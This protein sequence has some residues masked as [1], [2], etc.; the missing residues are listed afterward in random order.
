MLVLAVPYFEAVDEG[1]RKLELE[2]VVYGRVVPME[3]IKV[4]YT[5]LFISKS[6]K[7]VRVFYT[8]NTSLSSKSENLCSFLVVEE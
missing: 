1:V 6:D 2:L 3:H 7:L 4:V 8:H 5:H